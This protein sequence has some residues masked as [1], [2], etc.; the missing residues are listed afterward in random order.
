MTGISFFHV[1]QWVEALN[2]TDYL[3][4]KIRY[5][6][7]GDRTDTDLGIF[8]ILEALLDCKSARIYSSKYLFK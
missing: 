3:Y 6:K 2:L 8:Y 4:R 1:L 7:S 5:R